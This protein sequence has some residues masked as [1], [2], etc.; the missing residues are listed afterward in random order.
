[1][2]LVEDS[3]SVRIE[4]ALRGARIARMALEL[5][6]MSLAPHL[7]KMHL[8]DIAKELRE[9]DAFLDTSKRPPRA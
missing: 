6:F 4:L 5:E 2:G 3:S 7:A 9:L 1:M 8:I